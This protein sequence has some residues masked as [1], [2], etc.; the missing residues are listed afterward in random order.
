M[1]VYRQ[2]KNCRYIS[3][4]NMSTMQI[5]ESGYIAINCNK[6]IHNAQII[7]SFFKGKSSKFGLW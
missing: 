2:K 7:G 4:G 6:R 3:V 5:Y 1:L